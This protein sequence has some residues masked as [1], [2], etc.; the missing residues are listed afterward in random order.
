MQCG[1]GNTT[2]PDPPKM[3]DGDV[4][5]IQSP[6]P[7][8]WLKKLGTFFEVAAPKF[9]M[10]FW[11]ILML[12]CLGV[13][14]IV[15]LIITGDFKPPPGAVEPAT[16]ALM[17]AKQVLEKIIKEW[18]P[19]AF[20]ACTVC[21]EKSV[22]C[23]FASCFCVLTGGKS[24]QEEVMTRKV[25]IG[26]RVPRNCNGMCKGAKFTRRKHRKLMRINKR[27][28]MKNETAWYQKPYKC[29]CKVK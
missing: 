18:L 17:V 7:P 11:I 28:G 27:K 19:R 29:T 1:D 2:C 10:M 9:L 12:L 26:W 23:C 5:H 21:C 16:A 13:I 24:K 6:F 20:Q 3:D 15:H 22:S 8:D 25:G 4:P 14:K